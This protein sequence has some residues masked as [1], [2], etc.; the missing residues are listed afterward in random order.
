MRQGSSLYGGSNN[1]CWARAPC[2]VSDTRSHLIT[3]IVLA[4]CFS[5]ARSV[6]RN[7]V[8][9]ELHRQVLHSSSA[10]VILRLFQERKLVDSVRAYEKW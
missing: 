2:G 4:V 7:G 9:L 1:G 8:L 10:H 3:N 6:K 5:K